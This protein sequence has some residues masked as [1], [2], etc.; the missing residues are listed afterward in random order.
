MTIA[1]AKQALAD[2]H[3]AVRPPASRFGHAVGELQG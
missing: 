3:I 1:E 2:A